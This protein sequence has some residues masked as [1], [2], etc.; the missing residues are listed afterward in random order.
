MGHDPIE[1]FNTMVTTKAKAKIKDHLK[2]TILL[3]IL[4]FSTLIFML[5]ILLLSIFY[6]TDSNT[7]SAF[8]GTIMVTMLVLMLEVIVLDKRNPFSEYPLNDRIFLAFYILKEIVS[9]KRQKRFKFSS[10]RK[11]NIL[12]RLLTRNVRELKENIKNQY[13]F[14]PS[15]EQSELVEAFGEVVKNKLSLLIKAKKDFEAIDFIDKAISV[16]CLNSLVLR[17]SYSVSISEHDLKSRLDSL[18]IKLDELLSF[19]IEKSKDP[20]IKRASSVIMKYAKTQKTINIIVFMAF[21]IILFLY[22]YLKD[23]T[24]IISIIGLVGFLFTVLSWA[25]GFNKNNKE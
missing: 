1:L 2:F 8:S 10:N 5:I 4:T 3:Q 9:E 22:F 14:I 19:S 20:F 15:K 11:I 7:S 13:I 16:Y 24:K 23:N 25:Q 21:V 18:E 12:T 17:T 6:I